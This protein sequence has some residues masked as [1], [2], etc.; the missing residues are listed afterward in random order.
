M[1]YEIRFTNFSTKYELLQPLYV[2]VT[3]MYAVYKDYSHKAQHD[4]GFD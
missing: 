4:Q 2:K 1:I 3:K